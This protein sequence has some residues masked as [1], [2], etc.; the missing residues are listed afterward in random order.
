MKVDASMKEAYVLCRLLKV[1]SKA[2]WYHCATMT[3][4]LSK[5]IAPADYYLFPRWKHSLKGQSPEEVKML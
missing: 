4:V 2:E 5:C 1:E 3:T